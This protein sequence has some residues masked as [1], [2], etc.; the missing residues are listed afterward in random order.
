MSIPIFLIPSDFIVSMEK[1]LQP[2]LYPE[3]E[4]YYHVYPQVFRPDILFI[5]LFVPVAI[6]NIILVF[7]GETLFSE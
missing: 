6:G 3:A 5:L 7:Y 1:L 4:P 2:A